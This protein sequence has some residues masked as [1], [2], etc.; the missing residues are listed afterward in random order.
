MSETN[1]E[2]PEMTEKG[3][4]YSIPVKVVKS[5]GTFKCTIPKDIAKRILLTEK[6]RLVWVLR[7]DNTICIKKDSV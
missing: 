3:I 6:D 2:G 1:F 4:L 7:K 5:D